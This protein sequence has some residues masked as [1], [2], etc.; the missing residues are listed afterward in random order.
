MPTFITAT[1]ANKDGNQDLVVGLVI[2]Q[3]ATEP[4]FVVLLGNGVGGMSCKIFS[5]AIY[6]DPDFPVPAGRFA[7]GDINNDGYVDFSSF[8]ITPNPS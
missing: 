5:P 7:A 6:E 4:Q 2:D 8:I 3:G 1:D